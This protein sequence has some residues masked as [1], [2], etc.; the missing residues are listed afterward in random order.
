MCRKKVPQEYL[1]DVAARTIGFRLDVKASRRPMY[2]FN[3]EIQISVLKS[4]GINV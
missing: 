1:N 4:I 3:N 2:K